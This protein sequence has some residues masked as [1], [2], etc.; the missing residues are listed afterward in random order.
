MNA[1]YGP[2]TVLTVAALRLI[3]CVPPQH[4][5]IA[6][7]AQ[8]MA[9]AATWVTLADVARGPVTAEEVTERLARHAYRL[10]LLPE[11]V[12]AEVLL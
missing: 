2:E 1:R 10:G 6:A 4:H 12:P 5:S 8:S 9:N 11:P 3:T 7:V